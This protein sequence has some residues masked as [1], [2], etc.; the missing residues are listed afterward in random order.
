MRPKFQI[1]AAATLGVGLGVA[2][3][4]QSRLSL[5][6]EA[7]PADRFAQAAMMKA[8]ATSPA[9]SEA[10]HAIPAPAAPAAAPVAAAAVK[11][12]RRETRVNAALRVLRGRVARQSHPDALRY[13]FEAYFNFKAAHPEKVRKPYLYFVDYGLDSNTPRG[14]V[15]DMSALKVVDGPFTVAHGRGS[16]GNDA[17]PTRFS[18][19]NGSNTSSLGLFLAQETYA[20]SGHTGGRLYRSIGLRLT[21]LSGVFN[22]AARKR[23]VVVHGAPYVT[24]G[25]AGRSE[26]CPAIE[27]AR[28]WR[29]LPKIGNGGMVF[30]FSPLDSRWLT[31]DP[32]ANADAAGSN[33]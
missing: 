16:G 19:S 23:G 32:W 31:R 24:S 1:L 28:A 29:L 5:L 3:P 7:K 20:F 6:V 14:Y 10:A 12:A 18:N 13:A 11:P 17:V 21:G 8:L 4:H 30:L 27:P 25:K 33:G 22:S 26:G 2:L 15:F 9:A